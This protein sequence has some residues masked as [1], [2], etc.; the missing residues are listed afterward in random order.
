[1]RGTKCF[2]APFPGSRG[3]F[4]D[5]QACLSSSRCQYGYS[6]RTRPITDQSGGLVAGAHV[7][8]TSAERG[9]VHEAT[10]DASGVYQIL[11]LQPGPYENAR[12]IN[13]SKWEPD[14]L[15][16]SSPVLREPRVKFPGPLTRRPVRRRGPPQ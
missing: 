15:R 6:Q 10:T 7:K 16:G 12:A 9:T 13:G 4:P 8:A 1:M 14:E 5:R 11:S 3:D 2:C